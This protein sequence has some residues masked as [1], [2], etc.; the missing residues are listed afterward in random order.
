MRSNRKF[1]DQSSS[2]K[3]ESLFSGSATGPEAAPI[4]FIQL[5]CHRRMWSSHRFID[6]LASFAGSAAMRAYR[7]MNALAMPISSR[8]A[9]DMSSAWRFANSPRILEH[10]SATCWLTFASSA[11]SVVLAGCI[12]HDAIITPRTRGAPGV[13]EIVQVGYRLA[14]RE[15]SLVRVERAAKQHAQQL[16]GALRF[17]QRVQQFS[18]T[19]LVMLLELLDPVVGAAERLAV[20]RQHQHVL[21]QV[22]IARDR[23]EE[24]AQRV[25]FRVDR[26]D[27]DVGRDGGKQH[28]AG[29]QRIQ[30]LRVERKVLG[31]VAVADDGAPAVVADLDLV[32]L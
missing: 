6:R 24:Q 11:L 9:E 14:H 2:L 20:R 26:P 15:E 27:A 30:V 3:R 7:S 21:R 13:V 22:A 23:V 10:R 8:T 12:A 32:A 29:D 1:F 25:A 18:Q 17:F 19:V 4:S 28:V 31:R 16:G 5:D